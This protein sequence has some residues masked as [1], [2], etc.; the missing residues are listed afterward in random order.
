MSLAFAAQ[1]ERI[2][3]KLAPAALLVLGLASAAAMAVVGS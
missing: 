3:D 2:M 1:F